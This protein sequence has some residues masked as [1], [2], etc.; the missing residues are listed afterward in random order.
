MQL[1]GA[2]C[3]TVTIASPRA[4]SAPAGEAKENRP[5]PSAR[6]VYAL[7]FTARNNVYCSSAFCVSKLLSQGWRL[8]DPG[9][10]AALVKEL[11]TGRIHTS[12]T[13]SL[14]HPPAGLAPERDAQEA[15]AVMG[16]ALV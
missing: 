10:L 9:Q 5:Q 11:S 7:E 13:P 6:T 15:A 2:A 12:R 4:P 16:F 3:S 1:E 14:S 8:S